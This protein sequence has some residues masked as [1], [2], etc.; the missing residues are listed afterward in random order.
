MRSRLIIEDI[1]SEELLLATATAEDVAFVK[2]FA[3]LGR[4]CEVLA[5]RA[6]VHRELGEGVQILYDDYGAPKVANSNRYISVSHSHDKV[7]VLF[8]DAPCA[9]DIESVERDF[10][11]VASR[12]LSAEEQAMAERHN[13]YAELWSAKEALYKY[14]KKGR[15]DLVQNISI[16]EYNAEDS[17]LIATI[18]DSYP[19]MVNIDRR[20]NIVIATID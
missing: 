15:L 6:I 18:L 11:K 17:T 1:C 7:A 12:Y 8:S 5:W 13:L 16:V 3:N 4:R 20:D 2:Q 14:Y 10:R 9:V 19:I